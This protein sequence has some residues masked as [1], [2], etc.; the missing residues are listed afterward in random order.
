MNSPH[1]SERIVTST[2][3]ERTPPMVMAQ[4]VPQGFVD[5]E[6]PSNQEVVIPTESSSWQQD[7]ERLGGLC[8]GRWCDYRRATIAAVAV[9]AV[10]SLL[11]IMAFYVDSFNLIYTSDVTD[12]GILHIINDSNHLHAVVN[13]ITVMS[14]FLAFVGA[15]QFKISAI[16]WNIAWIMLSFTAGILIRIRTTN[17]LNLYNPSHEYTTNW[18][19][20]IV[21]AVLSALFMYPQIA[22]I[23]EVKTGVLNQHTYSRESYSCCCRAERKY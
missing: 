4:H 7:N 21:T 12:K 23:H 6:C 10:T 3:L 18:F 5:S 22:F 8:C 16:S 17:N 13:G 11:W 1:E 9:E 15:L 14:S 2:R 20:I 19:I